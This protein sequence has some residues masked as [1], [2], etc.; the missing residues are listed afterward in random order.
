MK[1][2]EANYLG[3]YCYVILEQ[4]LIVNPLALVQPVDLIACDPAAA[5]TAV[6]TLSDAN[7]DVIA[8]DPT[9]DVADFTF[10]Y[11]LNLA[12]A[13]GQTGQLPDTY[14]N[15][16]NPQDV[17]VAVTNNDTGCINYAV[18]TL[19]VKAGA[20]SASPLDFQSCDTDLATPNGVMTLILSD[21]DT[22]VLNGQ[23]P[24]DFSVAWFAT[25]ADA[26]AGTPILANSY[27]A[28]S[29]TIYAVVTNNATGCRSNS[30]AFVILIEPLAEPVITNTSNTICVDF[31]GSLASGLT[32]TSNL[33]SDANYTLEWSL[34]GVVVGTGA[35]YTI[36]D[37]LGFGDYTLT[38]TSNSALGCIS[39]P[40]AIFN[41]VQS[42]QA[43]IPSGTTGFL[44]SNYFEDNQTITITVDGN[45]SGFYQYQLDEGPIMDNGGVFTNVAPRPDG[46]AHV[47]Y[48]YDFKGIGDEHCDPLVINDIR[49]V[50][51]PHYFTP[52]GDGIHDTWNITGLD[53]SAKIYI[54]DR[55]GKFLKQIA[56]NGAGWDGTFNG[57]QLPSTDYWFTVY[58]SELNTTTNANKEF[59]AHFS[60]KR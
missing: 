18:V 46:Q 34:N 2:T 54:F 60:L 3:E 25:Q 50:D 4:Q 19:T 14:T 43:H 26:L 6:F 51:Y 36:T 29:G 35:T 10:A 16:S 44:V 45:G 57:K 42:G 8:L 13:Q 40:S 1:G 9:Q 5:A 55:Y 23:L 39:Q 24:A 37:P 38:A 28:S 17:V 59:K 11:Y 32:L 21:Y 41:V 7:S 48:V 58:Y 53:G 27:D 12:D 20:I 47:V 31:D 30:A 52:N 56:P 15:I 49:L 22:Q 33:S